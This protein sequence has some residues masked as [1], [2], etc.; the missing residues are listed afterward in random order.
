MTMKKIKMSKEDKK[1]KEKAKRLYKTYGITLEEYDELLR[2]QNN[3]CAVCLD[4]PGSGRLCVDHL[5]QKGFRTMPPEEKKK[6][7]RGLCCFLC[8]VSFKGFEK[9]KDG[10]KNRQRLEGTYKYF[11][12]YSLK[13]EIK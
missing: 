5:H 9:T 7:V 2:Q 8:N 6:Y 3:V 10:S 1:L 13:G 11:K 12:K 4:R